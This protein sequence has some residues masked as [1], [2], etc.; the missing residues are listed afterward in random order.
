M[1]KIK[2]I[3]KTPDTSEVKLKK[4]RDVYGHV[5]VMRGWA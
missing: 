4:I 1:R 3:D 2:I 5:L